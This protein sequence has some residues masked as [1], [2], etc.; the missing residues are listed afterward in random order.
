MG[1]IKQWY[2]FLKKIL[3]FKAKVNVL[4]TIPCDLQLETFSKSH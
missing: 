1:F 3:D 2:Y 4:E